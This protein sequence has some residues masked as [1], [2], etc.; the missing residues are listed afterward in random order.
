MQM[1]ERIWKSESRYQLGA[2]YS[3]Q[4]AELEKDPRRGWT[5]RERNTRYSR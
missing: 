4:M 1:W 5:T 3:R 2:D